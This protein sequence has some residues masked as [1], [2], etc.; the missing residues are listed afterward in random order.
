MILIANSALTRICIAQQNVKLL[1]IFEKKSYHFYM[2]P[3]TCLISC[4]K[5]HTTKVERTTTMTAKLPLKVYT[6]WANWMQCK[7]IYGCAC[8]IHI[9]DRIFVLCVCVWKRK[10]S[11]CAWYRL[12]FARDGILPIL[13]HDLALLFRFSLAYETVKIKCKDF[14]YLSLVYLLRFDYYIHIRRNKWIVR[15][16]IYLHIAGTCMHL[17]VWDLVLQILTICV[18]NGNG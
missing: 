7:H 17:Y 1:K 2:H 8:H 16:L 4:N 11:L 3:A 14:V 10:L 9:H 15:Q 12:G 18:L 5:Q 6:D 13:S